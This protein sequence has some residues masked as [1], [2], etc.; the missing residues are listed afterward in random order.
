MIKKEKG[1]KTLSLAIMII[2]F[3]N[4]LLILN[5]NNN[6]N[7]SDGEIITSYDF[8][9]FYNN[10]NCWASVGNRSVF[11]SDNYFYF[12]NELGELSYVYMPY[13]VSATTTNGA[14][15]VIKFDDERVLCVNAYKDTSTT[16]MIN[17][18]MIN[19][20]NY[21]VTIYTQG[22]SHGIGT[23]PS[24]VDNIVIIK[25]SDSD[26]RAIISTVNAG[27]YFVKLY[28]SYV[29]TG[30]YTTYN[31]FL[32]KGI[33]VYTGTNTIYYIVKNNVTHLQLWK[34]DYTTDQQPVRTLIDTK[35]SFTVGSLDTNEFQIV[36]LNQDYN[37]LNSGNY[38]VNFYYTMRNATYNGLGFVTWVF[39]G[40]TLHKTIGASLSVSTSLKK[41]TRIIS[42]VGITGTFQIFLVDSTNNYRYMSLTMNGDI[43]DFPYPQ[44]NYGIIPLNDD[45]S[46]PYFTYAGVDNVLFDTNNLGGISD[47]NNQLV[48]MLDYTEL[49][50]YVKK[51]SLTV[52]G[53]NMFTKIES[54]TE[55]EDFPVS[56]IFT[57]K[58]L[59]SDGTAYA[60][61]IEYSKTGFFDNPP[62]T[63]PYY[64]INASVVFNGNYQTYDGFCNIYVS[65]ISLSPYTF[66]DVSSLLE[67]SPNYS[68][69][70][71]NGNFL[72]AYWTS[73]PS[74]LPNYY[75]Q[76]IVFETN[77]IIS[78]NPLT[79]QSITTTIFIVAHK[80][81]MN[82]IP[83]DLPSDYDELPQTTPTPTSG[84]GDGTGT[85]IIIPVEYWI[86]ILIYILFTVILGLIIGQSGVFI[87]LVIATIICLICGLI[88]IWAVI[89]LILGIILLILDRSG[90]LSK[91]GD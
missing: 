34:I 51:L 16:I 11:C 86:V 75:F 13:N 80:N 55:Y 31:N 17:V 44:T 33:V 50:F 30:G 23:N 61:F 10:Q 28:P 70:F 48:F 32:G 42:V 72:N 15:A 91:T 65:S 57:P 79:Y 84:T 71:E 47:N 19:V 37:N 1:K 85:G 36:L 3:L 78:D 68:F 29:A 88:P 49:R 4:I 40:T 5:L 63:Q 22:M 54:A 18:Y 35:L 74:G 77:Y 58:I 45:D 7:A 76:L 69:N 6:V 52:S 43:I 87:G 90:I 26:F 64:I 73:E 67:D 14:N 60:M 59:K 62:L 9:N 81:G 39:D 38:T 56:F 20:F 89:V 46:V 82:P 27:D 66:N 12:Y 21:S 2:L 41:P 83:S 24:E 25:L 8:D 53:L